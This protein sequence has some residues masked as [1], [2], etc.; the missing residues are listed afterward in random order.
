M[1]TLKTL[2]HLGK[3]CANLFFMW[4]KKKKTVTFVKSKVLKLISFYSQLVYS[5]R[6]DSYGAGRKGCMVNWTASNKHSDTHMFSTITLWFYWSG[7]ILTT[8]QAL[9]QRPRLKT[10]T[11]LCLR[12]GERTRIKDEGNIFCVC[13]CVVKKQ[14]RKMWTLSSMSLRCSGDVAHAINLGQIQQS[15]WY[16]K[17]LQS[18]SRQQHGLPCQR[19]AKL[20]LNHW[21]LTYEGHHSL[22]RVFILTGR[23]SPVGV[24]I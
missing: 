1:N 6:L 2:H 5:W 15:K 4:P 10:S 21:C 24:L 14:R 19:V 18:I 16:V 17:T 12:G 11:E 20:L 23:L 22:T 9:R 8:V 3:P 13:V 7:S